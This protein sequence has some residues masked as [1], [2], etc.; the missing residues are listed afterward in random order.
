MC[1]RRLVVV[2]E[3]GYNLQYYRKRVSQGPAHQLAHASH[4][5][6]AEPLDHAH[7]EL[8]D[9][10]EPDP[11]RA[12]H[13]ELHEQPRHEYVVRAARW[14]AAHR[15]D[16]LQ[17]RREQDQVEDRL[18]HP[19]GDPGRVVDEDREVTAEDQPR[20]A[21]DFHA[22]V[23]RS[24]RPVCRRNT[25]SKLGRWSST[26]LSCRS[27][28]SSRRRICGIATS[29]RSTYRRTKPF[30]TLASRTKGWPLTSSNASCW[31]PAML[32]VT[33]SPAIARFKS[34]GVP[35]ATILP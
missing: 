34:S 20:V 16:R 11:G 24:E 22:A 17:Q 33:T 25:S 32:S 8:G 26:V 12:E 23:S 14:E 18:Q 15:G 13:A 10:A 30:S 31:S 3:S 35:S 29:P 19:D 5:S 9:Q 21:Q 7:A 2:C 6:D 28:P 27:A 1:D 4:R